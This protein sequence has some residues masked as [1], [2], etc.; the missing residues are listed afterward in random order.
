MPL[1]F[2]SSQR[3]TY[4]FSMKMMFEAFMKLGCSL[5]ELLQ[6]VRT[7]FVRLKGYYYGNT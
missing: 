5:S 7:I 3:R 1:H 2:L 4:G 6:K